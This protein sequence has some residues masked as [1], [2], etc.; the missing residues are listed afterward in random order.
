[1]QKKA[2]KKA[3]P[4]KAAPKKKPMAAGTGGSSPDPVGP[5]R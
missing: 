1:M 4:K 3:A 2:S 5:G